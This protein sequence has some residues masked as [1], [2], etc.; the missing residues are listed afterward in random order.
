V[1]SIGGNVTA[2][3]QVKAATQKMNAIGGREHEW[4]TIAELTG[5]LDL[6]TS[7]GSY[8]T[9]AQNAK[10]QD[11]S[12]V[13]MCDYQS[14]DVTTADARLVIGKQ[15]YAVQLF[16]NPMGMDKH[17]EIYCNYLEGAVIENEQG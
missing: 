9:L 14:L 7:G 10:L 17:Y 16:D 4:F 3:V 6:A 12:H 1:D 2:Q 11:S 5:F 15:I 8:S 13:F